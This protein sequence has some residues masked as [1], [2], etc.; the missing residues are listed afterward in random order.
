MAQS[1][2]QKCVFFFNSYSSCLHVLA[3]SSERI[4]FPFRYHLGSFTETKKLF[5]SRLWSSKTTILWWVCPWN[6]NHA[7]ATTR[8]IITPSPSTIVSPRSLCTTKKETIKMELLSSILTLV[9]TE[10]R[11]YATYQLAQLYFVLVVKKRLCSMYPF[12]FKHFK[13]FAQ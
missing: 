2:I 1:I 10:T 5:A 12:T 3:K 7:T 11:S 6:L 13:S 4:L 9:V 8:A